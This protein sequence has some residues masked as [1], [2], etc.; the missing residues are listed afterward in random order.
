MLLL[1]A[2]ASA[3]AGV[4]EA[5][6]YT[7]GSSGVTRWLSNGHR[8][9]IEFGVWSHEAVAESWAAAGRFIGGSTAGGGGDINTGGQSF[10]LYA[11]PN[12]TPNPFAA[13]TRNFAKPALTTGD[14]FSFKVSMNNRSPGNRGFD[15]R[16]ASGKAG[17]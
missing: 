15:L 5:S 17:P 14:V 10:G 9:D 2:L 13:S 1:V 11:N 8:G 7:P 16:N 3:L 4:D 6:R 12:G